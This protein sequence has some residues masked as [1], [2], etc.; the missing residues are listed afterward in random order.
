[1]DAGMG[2]IGYDIVFLEAKVRQAGA[3]KSSVFGADIHP[4][5][6]PAKL[7]ETTGTA[8]PCGFM[9]I[10]PETAYSFLTFPCKYVF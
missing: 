4:R 2:R 5:G 1:M 9:T 3:R 8:L 6:I 10:G 7:L